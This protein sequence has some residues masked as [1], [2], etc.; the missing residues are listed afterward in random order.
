M[1]TVLQWLSD[2][3]LSYAVQALPQVTG[4]ASI[5]GTYWRDT[6]IVLG[7]VIIGLALGALTL[8]RQPD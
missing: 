1:A 8:R 7:C 6:G 2:A 4:S 5:N 3:P